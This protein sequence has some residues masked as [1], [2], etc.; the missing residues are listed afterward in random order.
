[1]P[2][3]F[4]PDIA[5]PKNAAIPPPPP[6]LPTE[7]IPEV[8]LPTGVE[9]KKVDAAKEGLSQFIWLPTVGT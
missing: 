4:S 5:P 7:K 3:L 9:K 8:E 1:M 6:V 2:K